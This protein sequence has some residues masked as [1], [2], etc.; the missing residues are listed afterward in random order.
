MSGN[1]PNFNRQYRAFPESEKLSGNRNFREWSSAIMTEFQ[2]L[3]IL[4]TLTSEGAT[5]A[6]WSPQVR[7]RA[8]ALARSILIQSVT[9]FIKPQI[10]D[11]P[12]AF[13]IWSLL[14]TRYQTA[15]SFEP[16]KLI[17]QIERL[18]FAEAG[19]A[20]ALI[21]QGITIR[22]KHRLVSNKLLDEFYWASAIL[23][24]LL[25]F[26]QLETQFLMT[27]PDI[28]LEQIHNYFAERV[29]DSF[30]P[31]KPNALYQIAAPSDAPPK[32]NPNNPTL[33]VDMYNRKMY[34]PKSNNV[35]PSPS[36]FLGSSQ[37][38]RYSAGRS[39]QHNSNQQAAQLPNKRD[40]P[41]RAFN[42]AVPILRGPRVPPPR[43]TSPRAEGN[44]CIGCGMTGH[45]TYACPYGNY[46]F[47]YRCKRFGHIRAECRD[48]W[49]R[50]V[51]G[52][53]P[54]PHPPVIPPYLQGDHSQQQVARTSQGNQLLALQD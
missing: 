18:T 49:L 23:R 15:S 17:T 50:D 25:P 27:F 22:D 37:S 44:K 52:D 53:L 10:H 8:D 11:L 5:T 20:I 42:P 31:G 48:E 14:L 51:P 36:S 39:L 9:D 13:Q 35:H 46:P 40:I 34:S 7:S 2:V 4:E 24:K 54:M 30:E 3:G 16:H 29:F 12:S 32:P 1:A 43:G 33:A 21:E 45:S 19:S 26:Y 28:T 47:C 38:Q 41:I 6:Q